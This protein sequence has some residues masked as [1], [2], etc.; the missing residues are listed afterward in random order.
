MSMT[1]KLIVTETLRYEFD[2]PPDHPEDQDSLRA[3]FCAK[4]DPWGEADF[5]AITERDF[6]VEILQPLPA[7]LETQP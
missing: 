6:D 5:A 7:C 4:A 3:L 2:L 1:K